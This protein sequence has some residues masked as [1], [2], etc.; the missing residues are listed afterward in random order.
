MHLVPDDDTQ[1]R[2]N[3]SKI[4]MSET[5][6]SEHTK[7]EGCGCGGHGKRR[8]ERA[9]QAASADA[10]WPSEHAVHGNAR[11]PQHS[12]GCGGGNKTHK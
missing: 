11:D 4:N 6:T 12:S 10:A 2:L 9:A 7:S 5:D 8:K 3:M 1:R